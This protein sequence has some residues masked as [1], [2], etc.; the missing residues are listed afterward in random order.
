M[1]ILLSTLGT[2]F[3]SPIGQTISIG[4]LIG[5]LLSAA[6]TIAGVIMLFLFIGGGLMIIASATSGDSKGAANGKQ[7]VT[8]AL[9]GFIIIFTA[10]WFIRI[11]ELITGTPFLT[12]P[13]D[14]YNNLPPAGP[15]PR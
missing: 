9:I 7:A 3:G 14:I 4:D 13:T 12:N 1:T 11:I 6:L 5:V 2:A 10:Y 15:G 8:W